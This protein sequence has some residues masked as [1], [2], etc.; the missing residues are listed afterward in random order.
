MIRPLS[1]QTGKSIS[2][3]ALFS[4]NTLNQ[5]GKTEPKMLDTDAI[6]L[7]EAAPMGAGGAK[8]TSVR[9][10]YDYERAII[11]EMPVKEFVEHIEK[12]TGE[13]VPFINY[14]A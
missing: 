12:E 9:L 8:N 6:A 10:K 2:F 7:A 3:N 14:E 11:V 5:R 1:V 4:V 13:K